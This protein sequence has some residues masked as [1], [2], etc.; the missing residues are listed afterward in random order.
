MNSYQ[1]RRNSRVEHHM[2]LVQPLARHYAKKSGQDVDDLQQVGL[3]GL[4]R[5]AELYE[6]RRRI[7]FSAFAR[8]HIR[9]AILHYLR[10]KAAII[11]MPRSVQDSSQDIGT[12]FNAASQGRRL[13]PLTDEV[14]SNETDICDLLMRVEDRQKLA[15]AMHQL[16]GNE[17]NALV[18]VILDGQSLRKVAQ[19]T[20][21][22]AMTIQRRVK[23]GLRQLRQHLNIQLE[24]A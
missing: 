12:G 2:R 9:G 20:G 1:A 6:C 5:A 23:R 22:S 7:P 15:N 10:D 21:V 19:Q 24:L 17:R 13:I 18:Q 3:L 14:I 11:R 16:P 4:L 8:P